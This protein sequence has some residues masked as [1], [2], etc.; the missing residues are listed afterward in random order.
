MRI[1]LDVTP[2]EYRA[3]HD[4]M[5]YALR[6][7][8]VGDPETA[9]LRSFFRKYAASRDKVLCKNCKQ[10]KVYATGLCQ[11]CYRAEKRKAS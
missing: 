8:L 1:I 9:D 5:S 4:L 7:A 6:R 2:D 3:A 11:A 10:R